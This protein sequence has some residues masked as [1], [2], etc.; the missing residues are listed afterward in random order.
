M[1]VRDHRP[2]RVAR[3]GPLHSEQDT[4]SGLRRTAVLDELDG[5]M[6]IDV[7]C[8]GEVAGRR[9]SEPGAHER[10][11]PPV[12]NKCFDRI[13]PRGQGLFEQCLHI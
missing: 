3:S 9:C 7:L 6:E 2:D 5:R 1:I 10:L 4:Q 13:L 11:G 12:H 8:G